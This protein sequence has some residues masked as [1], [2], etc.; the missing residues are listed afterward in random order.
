M[1]VITNRISSVLL[2][3]VI[4][5]AFIGPGTLAA[6][7]SAGALYKYSLIWALLFAT[8]ACIVLQEMAARIGLI[9]QNGL[10]EA[11][12]SQIQNS[13][14][15]IG[16]SVL[17]FVAIIFGNAAYEAGNIAGAVLGFQGIF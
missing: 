3:S 13:F 10:G 16:S 12:N 2:W 4:S 1:F 8:L 14:V 5:A 6:A 17:I 11:I 9:T 7:S 15:K